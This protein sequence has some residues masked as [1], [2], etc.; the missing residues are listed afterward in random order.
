MAEERFR[1]WVAGLF[2]ATAL[3][4]A[5]V[6]LYGLAARFVAERRREIAIR[7]ALGARP[8]DV[9]WFVY[10][11][12]AWITLAGAGAGL[13]A[14]YAAARLAAAFLYGVSPGEPGVFALSTGVLAVSAAMACLIPARRAVWIDPAVALRD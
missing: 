1:G 11:D 12:V 9:R 13:P 8:A 10:R 14:A 7:I 6:S 4:L 3:V 5:A 2:G